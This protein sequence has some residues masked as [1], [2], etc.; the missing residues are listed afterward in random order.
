MIRVSV[1]Y[2]SG[3]GA[4]FDHEYYVHTHIPMVAERLG[5]VL[6][7]V[8]VDRGLFGA[9]PGASPPYLAVAHLVFDSVEEYQSAMGPH[10][11]QF[12]AD[13]PNYTNVAPAVQV[14]EID[15]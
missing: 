14:S 7:S 12:A 5:P 4:T 6:K 11:P 10:L 15:G 3:N 1:M 13:Q 2:P 8:I 9:E